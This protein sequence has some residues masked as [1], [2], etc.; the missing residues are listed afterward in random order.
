MSYFRIPSTG[1]GRAW[2]GPC[3]IDQASPQ[4][5]VPRASW[6]LDIGGLPAWF[7]AADACNGCPFLADCL[8]QRREFFPTSNPAGVIWAGVAYSETGRI[9][10]TSGLRRLAATRRNRDRR[11]RTR[12]EVMAEV[13]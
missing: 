1:N 12:R 11:G 9:L 10:G 7:R 13:A 2:Q 4:D 3:A 5:A 8:A 6:D